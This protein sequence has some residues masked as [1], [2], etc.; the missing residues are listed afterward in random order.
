[1]ATLEAAA[2]IQRALDAIMSH[3]GG[4][5]DVAGDPGGPT[6]RGVTLATLQAIRPDATVAD[7]KALSDADAR[8]IYLQ[9][10]IVQPHID[11]LP[12][13]IIPNVADASV[14]CGQHEA[15]VLLQLALSSCEFPVVLDGVIGQGTIGAAQRA[16]G[17]Y[18]AGFNDTICDARDA[19]YRSIAQNRPASAQFLAGWLRR[20]DSFRVPQPSP[21]VA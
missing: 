4:W 10:Y 18:G 2:A 11:Q 17:R 8:L 12:A 6:N 7:L 13:E 20:S 15:V 9:R 19:H 3:E 5:S 14:N 1:M 16:V 21:E